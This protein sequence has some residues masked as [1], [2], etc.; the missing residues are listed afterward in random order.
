M[1]FT[2]SK[3]FGNSRFLAIETNSSETV[4]YIGMNDEHSGV[5]IDKTVVV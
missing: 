4:L 2:N 3:I 1:N 5:T